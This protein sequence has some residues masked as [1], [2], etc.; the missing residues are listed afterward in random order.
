E[1]PEFRRMLNSLE[2][3]RPDIIIVAKIDRFARSLI[4]LLNTIDMLQEKNVGFISVQDQ[5]IDTTSANG[6]LMLQILGAFAEFERNL[7]NSRTKAGREKAMALG[8][9]FGRPQLKT[10]KKNGS[11]FVDPRKIMELHEKG[12]SARAISKS[13]GCS[14]TPVLKVINGE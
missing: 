8:V 14:I 5:G 2:E 3:K 9:K 10:S 13:I 4:D 7:I 12:L 11:K 6:K 1:R